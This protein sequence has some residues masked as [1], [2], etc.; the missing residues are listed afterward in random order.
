[1]KPKEFIEMIKRPAKN[2][3]EEHGIPAAVI[4]AQAALETGWLRHQI[5]DKYT[6]ENSYNLFGIKA[7]GG[8][9]GKTV[10]ID[11]HEFVNGE[12]VKVEDEFRAYDCFEDSILDHMEFLFQN[13]RYTDTLTADNP[14]EFARELQ[15]AGYA[16]DPDY[17]D[18]LISIMKTYDLLEISLKDKTDYEGHWA[19]REIKKCMKTG[20]FVETDKFRPGDSLTRA[21]MAVIV[22]RLI[23]FI[24][25][26]RREI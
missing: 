22:D 15:K 12:R 24:T 14:I 3:Q 10:T 26:E 9:K 18:K 13:P 2:I 1:M 16:T 19:E 11:T 4:I 7:H 6:G 17:A 5:K 23:R 8:W 25:S 21:E 20:I